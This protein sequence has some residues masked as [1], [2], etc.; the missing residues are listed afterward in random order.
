MTKAACVENCPTVVRIFGDF[1]DPNSEV[2]HLIKSATA[3][4]CTPRKAPSPASI[5]C[6]PKG[7]GPKGRDFFYEIRFDHGGPL[8]ALTPSIILYR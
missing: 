1:N 6:R 3:F 7:N 5:T 2:S 8:P 4:R